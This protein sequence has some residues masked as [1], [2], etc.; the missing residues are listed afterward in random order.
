MGVHICN[1]KQEAANLMPESQPGPI[2]EVPAV[3]AH[4]E[5][6]ATS[7]PQAASSNQKMVSIISMYFAFYLPSLFH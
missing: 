6:F 4:E 7:P 5:S 1:K 3:L 2:E